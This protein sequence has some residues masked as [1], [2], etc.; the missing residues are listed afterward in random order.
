MVKVPLIKKLS[1][2][3]KKKKFLP[4]TLEDDSKTV[5]SSV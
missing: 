2:I 1:I 3:N 4:G 5:V